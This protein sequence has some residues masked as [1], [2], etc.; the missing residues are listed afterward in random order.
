MMSAP[1]R[2]KLL[3]CE[4]E[5]SPPLDEPRYIEVALAFHAE[6]DDDAADALL[7]H[8]PKKLPTPLPLRSC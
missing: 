7:P 5:F 2:F 6:L 8:L 3:L 1:A 4:F